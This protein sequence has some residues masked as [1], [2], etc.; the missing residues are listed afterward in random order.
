MPEVRVDAAEVQARP[1][2]PVQLRCSS[3]GDPTPDITWTKSD[4]A[5]PGSAIQQGGILSI[6]SVAE[7]DQGMKLPFF[8][9][10]LEATY[11][12]SLV[13]TYICTGTSPQGSR[14]AEV[15]LL[16]YPGDRPSF[17][18]APRPEPEPERPLQPSYPV[19]AERPA[20]T[21]P[22]AVIEP[23]SITAYEGEDV[24]IVCRTAGSPQPTVRWYRHGGD[25]DER[26]KFNDT[27]YTISGVRG[28]KD[29]G[30]YICAA[31]SSV[32]L[33]QAS[34]IL[35]VEGKEEPRVELYPG[36][37]Q[38]VQLGDGIF[39][40]CQIVSGIPPPNITW[41]RTDGKPLTQKTNIADRPDVISFS[42]V[43]ADEVGAYTCTALNKHGSA[44]AT[45]NLQVQGMV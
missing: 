14:Q 27:T 2:E 10:C 35:D 37:S 38:T 25:P 6:D 11:Y 5:L 7:T 13:G 41:T 36:A 31:E 18:I 33:A 24:H 23:Q 15:R 39:F 22:T 45:A 30:I 9:T 17:P 34:G 3:S 43:S 16:V 32:G 42:E 29:R 8:L 4:G 20:G 19:E 44:S 1:G 12:G 26:H 21:P 28:E 40:Q